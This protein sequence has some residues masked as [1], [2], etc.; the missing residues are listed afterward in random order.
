M[1]FMV[2]PEGHFSSWMP[3][4]LT[5]SILGVSLVVLQFFD[6]IRVRL[7]LADS[8]LI[9]ILTA[10]FLITACLTCLQRALRK[11]PPAFKW[12]QLSYLLLIY[13]MRE[14]DFHRLFTQE[15]ISRMKLYTGP[16][17]LHEKILGGAI[18]L[19]S[20]ILLLHFMFSNFRF[21]WDQLKKRQPWAIQVIV[22]AILLFGS[23]A[24]D[25]SPWHGDLFEV[26]L[27]ENMEF[28]AAIMVLLVVLKYPIKISP[29]SAGTRSVV[30]GQH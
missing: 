27:E 8:G 23:Q 1:V 9:Q 7:L 16:Y 2:K 21:Y 26:I 29:L 11:I 13:A 12:A 4:Y 20:L 10:G 28:A 19:F 18:L 24:L 25:K 6:E 5:F 22:W 15:H 17:P 30:D 14:M 3:T